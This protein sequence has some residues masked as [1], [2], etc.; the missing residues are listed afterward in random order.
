MY[1]SGRALA[2]FAKARAGNDAEDP[3]GLLTRMSARGTLD[4]R[5]VGRLASK[6]YPGALG[7]A[8]E[9]ALWLGRGLVGLVNTFNPEMIV[10]GGGVADLGE[11]VLGP[12]RE[13]MQLNAMAPN[14][15]QV[16]VVPACLGN[17][18]GL[19]GAALS[20]WEILPRC[21]GAASAG[22]ALTGRAG[23]D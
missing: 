12:A 20:A 9:L 2:R 13:Y 22:G 18:A 10:V 11:I 5:T 4:G 21:P 3:G 7:A 23:D 6:G 15:D 16:R 17:S 14:R 19:V 1:A 8:Q